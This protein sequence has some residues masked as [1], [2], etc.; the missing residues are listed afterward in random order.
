MT[1]GLSASLNLKTWGPGW[2][3]RWMTGRRKGRP[4]CYNCGFLECGVSL[5]RHLGP[6]WDFPGPS[7]R[8]NAFIIRHD[9]VC[10]QLSL[11]LC[12]PMDCNPPG[13]S[14][15]GIFQARILECVASSRG[16][17]NP[18]IKPT[19]LESPALAGIF[20]TTVPPGKPSDF[21]IW[22]LILKSVCWSG[23]GEYSLHHLHE[24]NSA[25]SVQFIPKTCEWTH[26]VERERFPLIVST[27]YNICKFISHKHSLHVFL[28]LL[29][30]SQ[31]GSPP[32]KLQ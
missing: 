14:V 12:D 31:F 25:L 1:A 27:A 28:S 26:E 21:R 8:P 5:E 30:K 4:V 20:F 9:D 32:I 22:T 6:M 10:V 11:T 15:H 3:F 29:V 24:S 23:P 17:S 13:S 19:S 7:L 16:S 18:G 2:R